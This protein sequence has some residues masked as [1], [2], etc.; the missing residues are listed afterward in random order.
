MIS[1]TLTR[2]L[3][4]MM[5]SMAAASADDAVAQKPLFTPC[6]QALSTPEFARLRPVIPAEFAESGGCLRLTNH[7]F[8]LFRDPEG[9]GRPFYYCDLREAAPSCKPEAFGPYA[10]EIKQQFSGANGKRYLL[11]YNWQLRRGVF[12]DGYGI[13]S[14]VP[15][16]IQP[17]GFDIY[18]L[19]G[20]QMFQGENPAT[21]D[22]CRDVGDEAT[23]ITGY[24]LLGEG[25]A[26]VEL[27]FTQRRIDCK[28][29]EQ[30]QHVLRYRP[31]NGKFQSVAD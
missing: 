7:E 31:S 24:E 21:A 18:G 25:T 9:P 5:I 16:S 26:D 29:R 15:K 11:W 2:M 10:F 20:G 28:T 4:S 12:G 1:R 19:A 22:P 30:S 8:V 6:E 14:L 27:R 23:E 13:F 17:R 3:A